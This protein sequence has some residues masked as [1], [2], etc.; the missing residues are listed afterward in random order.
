MFFGD[1]EIEGGTGC[2]ADRTVFFAVREGDVT[3]GEGF[4]ETHEIPGTID[5]R[6]PTIIGTR[7]ANLMR[8]MQREGGSIHR[9][10]KLGGK[11]MDSRQVFSSRMSRVVAHPRRVARKVAFSSAESSANANTAMSK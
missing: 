7:F 3:A 9:A 10:Q 2:F 1:E 4:A 8:Y 11:T 5:A 6:L